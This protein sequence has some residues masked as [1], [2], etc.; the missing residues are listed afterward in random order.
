MC[1]GGEDNGQAKQGPA[2]TDGHCEFSF[3]GRSGEL[4]RILPVPIITRAMSVDHED[5]RRRRGFD[6]PL[7]S[8]RA[9]VDGD[10]R[11]GQSVLL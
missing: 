6:G 4:T 9:G 7:A 5:V 3:G 11:A 2:A 1:D 10:R 8:P